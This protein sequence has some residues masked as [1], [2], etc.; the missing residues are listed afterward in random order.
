MRQ[1]RHV[2]CTEI[3]NACRN[4]V[5]KSEAKRPLQRLMNRWEDNIKMDKNRVGV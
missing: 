3:K 1:L 5:H 2:A 4:L